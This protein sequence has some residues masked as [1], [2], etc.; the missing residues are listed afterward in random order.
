MA[1]TP[2]DPFR[3]QILKRLSAILAE[4]DGPNETYHYD[5]R[6]YAVGLEDGTQKMQRRVF[7]G[8]V[9]FGDTDPLPMVSILEVPLPPEQTPSS[10]DNPSQFGDWDLMLQGFVDDDPEDPTDPAQYLLADVKRRLAQER[11]NVYEGGILGFPAITKLSL[12]VGVVRPP[13]EI[14]AKAYFWLPVTI[15]MVEDLSDPYDVGNQ[16]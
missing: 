3:L 6:P 9:I 16:P 10:P 8:R 1:T 11:H 15:S 2:G 4:I 5:L 7:R 14:S 12:G 13:D